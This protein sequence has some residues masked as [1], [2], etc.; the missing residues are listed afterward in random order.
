MTK[1][2][3]SREKL[4]RHI[5]GTPVGDGSAVICDTCNRRLSTDDDVRAYCTQSARGR[6]YLRMVVCPE[7]GPVGDARAAEDDEAH[8]IAIVGPVTTTR[9][10]PM[11][12]LQDAR[13]DPDV[14]HDPVFPRSERV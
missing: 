8:I 11:H 3:N 12:T 10:G 13:L 2:L 1:A 5:R 14:V 4:A 7:C 9:Y 6:W